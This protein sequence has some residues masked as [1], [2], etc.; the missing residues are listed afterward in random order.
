M[1]EMNLLPSCRL[2]VVAYKE[3]SKSEGRKT[4]NGETSAAEI[5]QNLTLI[6]LAAI[7][8]PLRPEAVTAVQQCNRAGI[9]VRMLT[10]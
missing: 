7:S 4:S 9:T 1:F 2:I 5:E 10:G 3:E 8:D 6:A